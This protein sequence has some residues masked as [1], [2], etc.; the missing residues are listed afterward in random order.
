LVLATDMRFINTGL[1]RAE[2]DEILLEPD[3]YLLTFYIQGGAAAQ[4]AGSYPVRNVGVFAD[5]V[6]PEAPILDELA[7]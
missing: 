7:I 5:G 6:G 3:D 1:F 2:F 4:G